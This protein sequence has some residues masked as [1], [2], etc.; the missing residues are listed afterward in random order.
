MDSGETLFRQ[1]KIWSSLW[2]CMPTLLS[3]VAFLLAFPIDRRIPFWPHLNL[4][5]IFTVWFLFI[6]PIT[7]V[8]AIVALVKR[9][10]IGRVAL[11]TKSLVWTAIAVS[12]LVNAF[13][14]IGMWAST[15]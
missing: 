2:W 11:F 3:F 7:T 15:Y 9:K 14:L 6:T 10:R 12:L 1:E 4:A 5:E 13:V 8:I